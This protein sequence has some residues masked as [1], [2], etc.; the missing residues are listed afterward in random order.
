GATAY[1]IDIFDP[2]LGQARPA[3]TRTTTHDKE[4]LKTWAFFVQD[5]VALTERLKALAGVRFERF[6]HDYDDKLVNTRD[7]SK[8]EN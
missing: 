2:A 6:E 8:G 3:L 5:Q 7:F 1:P 4:N